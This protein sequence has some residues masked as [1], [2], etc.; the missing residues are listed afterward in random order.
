MQLV[1]FVPGIAGTQLNGPAPTELNYWANY[2]E[3]ALGGL[4]ALELAA[5]GVSPAS[6]C[7]VAL[8]PGL[9]LSAYYGS[10][11]TGLQQ[12]LGSQY[13]VVPWGYDWRQDL[14]TTGQQLAA[15]ILAQATAATPAVIVA[16]SAGGLVA[17]VAWSVLVAADQTDLV[18]RIIT[19]GTPHQGSYSVVQLFS[20]GNSTFLA[21]G[22]LAAIAASV[23]AALLVPGPV[24]SAVSIVELLAVVATWP[25]MYQLLPF[26]GSPDAGADPAVDATAGGQT[27]DDR[28]HRRY[29]AGHPDAA[30]TAGHDLRLWIDHAGRRGRDCGGRAHPRVVDVHSGPVPPGPPGRVRQRRYR[31]GRGDGSAQ[32]ADAAAADRCRCGDARAHVRGTALH[33]DGRARRQ[34]ADRPDGGGLLTRPRRAR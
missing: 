1:Y 31:R 4:I 9:P 20:Y 11:M 7:G 23:L 12:Q 2:T 16:H 26:L 25:S 21:L 29:D 22:T 14:L 28:G 15:A 24:C 13:V 17:R 27:Y 19:L 6:P 10:A 34:R 33:G 5:D 32:P 8:T 30:K 3:L 18:Q